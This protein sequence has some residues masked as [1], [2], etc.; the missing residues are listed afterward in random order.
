METDR[1]WNVLSPEDNMIMA[2][3]GYLESQDGK[4]TKTRKTKKKKDNSKKDDEDS[5]KTTGKDE[6]KEKKKGGYPEWKTIAPKE[7]E[8]T[9]KTV[10]GKEFHFCTKCR[11]GKGL[12][13]RHKEKDHKNGFKPDN[14]KNGNSGGQ[15]SKQ[16]TDKNANSNGNDPSIQVRKDLLSNAKA[17]LAARQ[18]FQGGGVQG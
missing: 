2:L 3:V 17:F 15:N 9:T 14:S 4:T 13:A 12:W 1:E 16:G 10:D 11:G 7:G 8:P 18:D 6:N 5:E